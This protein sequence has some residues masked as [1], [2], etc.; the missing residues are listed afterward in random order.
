MPI[1]SNK[2]GIAIAVHVSEDANSTLQL[3]EEFSAVLTLSYSR[4][5]M[6]L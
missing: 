3:R 1:I 5:G 4:G 2:A 6:C